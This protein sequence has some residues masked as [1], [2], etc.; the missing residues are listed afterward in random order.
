[1]KKIISIIMTRY[2]KN[3][4]LYFRRNVRCLTVKNYFDSGHLFI[5]LLG[6]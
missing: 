4:L 6:H 2:G 5:R 1:M 3:S